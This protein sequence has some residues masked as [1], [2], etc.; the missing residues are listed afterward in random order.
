MIP[1]CGRMGEGVGRE[2]FRALPYSFLLGLVVAQEVVAVSGSRNFEIVLVS[3]FLG[4]KE[5]DLNPEVNRQ[6]RRMMTILGVFGLAACVWWFDVSRRYL[7]H[8]GFAR[9]VEA[10][11]NAFD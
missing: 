3:L 2:I 8:L 4:L 5:R 7:V 1:V 6:R 9:G 10:A 11:G